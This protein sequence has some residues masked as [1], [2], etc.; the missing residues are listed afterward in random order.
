MVS[1][2]TTELKCLVY[3][4]HSPRLP[5]LLNRGKPDEMS[6]RWWVTIVLRLSCD[7]VFYFQKDLWIEGTVFPGLFLNEAMSVVIVPFLSSATR[8][9]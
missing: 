4:F 7:R 2:K 3:S 6:E 9:L 1:Q 5:S 8:F